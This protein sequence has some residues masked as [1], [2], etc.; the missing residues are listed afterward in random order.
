MFVGYSTVSLN[1]DHCCF[2]GQGARLKISTATVH[3][4]LHMWKEGERK[5]K[6]EGRRNGGKMKETQHYEYKSSIQHRLIPRS[7]PFSE[8]NPSV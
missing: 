7:L 1:P 8:Y 6:G 3:T 5:E 2:G 4:V